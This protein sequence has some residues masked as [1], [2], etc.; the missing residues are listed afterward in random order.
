MHPQAMGFGATGMG[1][2]ANW[3][4]KAAKGKAAAT[5]VFEL[6]DHRP[7]IDSQPWAEDGT[8]RTPSKS[9]ADVKVQP[10]VAAVAAACL[11]AWP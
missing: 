1:L 9:I 2:A 5:R 7:E 8:P 3:V 4:A 11:P 10:F 6:F